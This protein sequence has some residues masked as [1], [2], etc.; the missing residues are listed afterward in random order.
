MISEDLASDIVSVKACPA[1]G[2]S[3]RTVWRRD[4]DSNFP[5]GMLTIM[6]CSHCGLGYLD[7]RMSVAALERLEATNAFYEFEGEDLTREILA[8]PAM[9]AGIAG[10]VAGPRQTMLDV[11]CNRGLLLEA[12]RRDRLGSG[13]C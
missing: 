13:R 1:C 2:S 5:G 7:P 12:A 10:R 3:T 9:F 6:A 4:P 8:R 11:G